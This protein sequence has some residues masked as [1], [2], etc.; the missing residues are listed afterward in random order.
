[1]AWIIEAVKSSKY[2]DR[3]I[4]STD[5]SEY[6]AIA[7]QYGAETPFLRP[8]EISGDQATDYDYIRHAADWLKEKENYIPD[9][10]LRLM[11]TIPLQ[12][13]EDIDLC[14]EELLKYPDADSAVVVAPARQHPEKALK[15]IEKDG[16]K[17][18]VDFKSGE[19]KKVTPVARQSYEKAYFR[20][21]IIASR[22]ETVNSGSLTGDRVKFHIIPQERAVDIDSEIDFFILEE[23]IKKLKK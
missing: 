16:E 19:G 12:S 14:I 8:G 13:A 10:I 6:A 4:L 7:R 2:L 3:I 9:I 15:I 11:P 5:S 17:F 1:M 20:A 23:L 18:L 22:I 21:N